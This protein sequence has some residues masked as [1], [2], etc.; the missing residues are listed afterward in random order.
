MKPEGG[1]NLSIL[2]EKRREREEKIEEEE[3]RR[4]EETATHGIE[5]R[6]SSP[7]AASSGLQEN[8]RRRAAAYEKFERNRAKIGFTEPTKCRLRLIEFTDTKM[9]T[10]GRKP[11]NMGRGKRT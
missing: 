8:Q 10:K 4:Q 2:K 6:L 11:A 9:H 1:A 3:K 5:V 7:T